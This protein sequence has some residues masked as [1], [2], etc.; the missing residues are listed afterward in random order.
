[1]SPE[2]VK[3]LIAVDRM[4]ADQLRQRCRELLGVVAL[5]TR[6]EGREGAYCVIARD[7]RELELVTGSRDYCIGYAEARNEYSPISRGIADT[8]VMCGDFEVWPNWG[9]D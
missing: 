2:H 4:D 3:A 8:I 6:R 7:A 9:S 5:L 1:M